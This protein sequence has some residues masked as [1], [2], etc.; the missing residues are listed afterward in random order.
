MKIMKKEYL[1]LQM[2]DW[3]DR[4]SN[5]AASQRKF[6]KY[7]CCHKNRS[8]DKRSKGIRYI[9]YKQTCLLNYALKFYV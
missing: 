4:R 8:T 5:F 2:L 9:Y 6:R 3:K 1:I 7:I